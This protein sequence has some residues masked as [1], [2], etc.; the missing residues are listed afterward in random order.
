MTASLVDA[1]ALTQ[2][3]H[4]LA[5][6]I[7]ATPLERNGRMSARL[8]AEVLLKRED[9]Q[10][11]RSYQARGA[12]NLICSLDTAQRATV[13]VAASAGN[14]ARGSRRPARHSGR[15]AGCTR[16]VRTRARS[17]NGLPYRVALPLRSSRR[18]HV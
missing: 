7:A 15:A 12:F 18:R 10:P 11:V 6:Y 14:H 2:A 1:E 17:G 4:R 5:R 3:A 16:H 9:L 13:V 8:R